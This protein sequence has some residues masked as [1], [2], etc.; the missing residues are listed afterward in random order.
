MTGYIHGNHFN[1]Q[2][3]PSG[4]DQVAPVSLVSSKP[5]P[6][7]TAAGVTVSR[8]VDTAAPADSAFFETG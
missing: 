5:T 8:F 1:F 6:G 2:T 4:L 3:S 7:G